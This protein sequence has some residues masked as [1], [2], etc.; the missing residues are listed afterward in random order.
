MDGYGFGVVQ[1]AVDGNT[2][3]SLLAR[4]A[5]VMGTEADIYHLL[6]GT[7]DV[8]NLLPLATT[9]A[10]YEAI[11]AALRATGQP[12]IIGTIPPRGRGPAGDA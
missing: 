10:N 2:S 7:N 6:T 9:V 12:V 8:G 1:E 4:I 11:L 5:D 3:A